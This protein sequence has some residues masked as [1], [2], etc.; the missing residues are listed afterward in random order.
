M[1][2]ERGFCRW[3]KRI[4]SQSRIYEWSAVYPFY[5]IYMLCSSNLVRVASAFISIL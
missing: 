2:K 3:G 1:L 5:E 4:A